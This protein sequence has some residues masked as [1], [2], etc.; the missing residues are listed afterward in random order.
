MKV[1]GCNTL[2]QLGEQS[3]KKNANGSPIVSPPCFSHLNIREIISFSS[4]WDNS[5]WVQENGQA[6]AVGSNCF[7]Q[8]SVLIP[9][10]TLLKDTKILIRDKEGKPCKFL[11]AVCGEN[12]SLFQIVDDQDE[13]KSSLIY[14]YRYKTPL[15][16]NISGHMPKALFGGK[17][18]AA[19]IDT[20]GSVIIITKSILSS[21]KQ[22]IEPIP[23]PEND[24]AIKVACC[25]E[26]VLALGLS[27]RL[28]EYSLNYPGRMFCE[29]KELQGQKFVD[30]SGSL[31]HCFAV[32]KNGRVFGRGMND[33]GQLGFEKSVKSVK[34]FTP[35][36]SLKKQKI[37][38]AACG[39][40][41]SLFVTVEGKILSCGKNYYGELLFD[42]G[43]SRENIYLPIETSLQGKNPFCIAGCCTSFVILDGD[44]PKNTPNKKI[45]E[46]DD[47]R[48]KNQEEE[49]ENKTLTEIFDVSINESFNDENNLVDKNIN[50]TNI[51]HYSNKSDSNKNDTNKS[52]KAKNTKSY[53]DKNKKI[54]HRKINKSKN[55]INSN[56]ND[57]VNDK[58][59][60]L[61]I[62]ISKSD[63]INSKDISNNEN[64]SSKNKSTINN[65]DD[66]IEESKNDLVINQ[67]QNDELIINSN[68]D[69][70]ND[71]NINS[72]VDDPN[73]LI[74]N[75]SNTDNQN[76]DSNLQDSNV[77]NQN[78]SVEPQDT[79]ESEDSLRL[80]ERKNAILR[81]E[82][83]LAKKKIAILHKKEQ[84]YASLNEDIE[85][86]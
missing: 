46:D 42:S 13:K 86:K 8:I 72:N 55:E 7:G 17:E 36:D 82:L 41:H 69:N 39:C 57:T 62:N 47:E 64:D 43:P 59:N 76:D 71:D 6:Y 34:K 1:C 5:I 33:C 3:N 9:K 2:F 58:T 26:F 15:F 66:Y 56:E 63:V 21:P 23:L 28:F 40:S 73:S 35:I 51:E 85:T 68:D 18:T 67:N 16:L 44:V 65:E 45:N 20:D 60:I 37:A 29:V 10:K 77:E 11:S 81:L 4:Y 53:K 80:K 74:N 83:A 19:A 25:D 14:S 24:K 48:N 54:I 52:K 75:N 49:E 30:V 31:F 50:D 32:C 27:G 78:S 22:K 61:E 38:S 12:Y 84:Q 79:K 70:P